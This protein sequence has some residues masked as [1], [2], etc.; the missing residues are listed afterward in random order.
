[1]I[2]LQGDHIVVGRF[3]PET[4]PVDL[5]L[6]TSPEAAQIS[7][8]HAEIYRESDGQWYVKDLGSTNGVFVKAPGSSTFGPRITTPT[9]IPQGGE[10]AFGNARFVFR[11]D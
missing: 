3:D 1:M 6:S 7:R 4:G 11:A 2:P 9:P 5:D 10:L 8:N